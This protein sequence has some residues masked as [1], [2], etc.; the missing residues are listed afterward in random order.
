MEKYLRLYTKVPQNIIYMRN[1]L[2]FTAFIA[3]L[4]LSSCQPMENNNED[5]HGKWQA[6]SWEVAGIENLGEGANVLFEFKVDDNYTA[7]FGSSAES[8]IYRLE[9]TKLYT[10][11]E[12]KIEKLVK[13]ELASIDT[14]KMNMNRQGTAEV[15]TL[16]RE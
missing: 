8:G 5:I 4:I 3:T 12:G 16:V 1:Q 15:M 2:L 10:T 11:A 7:S 13:I 6:I 9:R 14:M